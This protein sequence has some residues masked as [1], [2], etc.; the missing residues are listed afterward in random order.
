LFE[1][2]NYLKLFWNQTSTTLLTVDT[3]SIVAAKML[4]P[5]LDVTNSLVGVEYNMQKLDYRFNPRKGWSILVRAGNG[6][7][8]IKKN[9]SIVGIKDPDFN[10][11]SLYDSLNLRS[12]QYRGSG[13]V[14]GYLPMFGRGVVKAGVQFGGIFGKEPVYFNEQFRIGGNRIMRGYDEESIFATR[15]AVFTLEYR[16]IIG[17]NSYLYGF[18]DYGYVENITPD[19]MRFEHPLGFGA[20]ITFE[21]KVG[22]FGFS[23]AL[24]R[25][26]DN[27]FDLRNVKSHFGYINVF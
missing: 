1:G 14:A 23:L 19:I 6:I 18:G 8:T 22:I 20:G 7:K 5:S 21:T 2:G 16:F 3:Q 12:F 9:A 24:G 13:N 17:Q 26:S 27:S 25:L 4:P 10:Y 11:E 15:F